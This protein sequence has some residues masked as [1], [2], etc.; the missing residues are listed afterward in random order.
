MRAKN[1]YRPSISVIATRALYEMGEKVHP[2]QHDKL[3]KLAAES[4]MSVVEYL[5]EIICRGWAA[6]YAITN[7][8]KPTKTYGANG[9][10]IENKPSELDGIL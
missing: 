7:Y 1:K 3:D 6:F 5:S 4:H 10:A 8:N 2:T 9:I